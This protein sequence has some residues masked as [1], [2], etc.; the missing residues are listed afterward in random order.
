MFPLISKSLDWLKKPWQFTH[1]NLT[2]AYY[3]IT[4]Q[5]KDKWKTVFQTKYKHYKYSVMS[6]RLTNF[7]TSF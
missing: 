1:L 3:E 7:T 5:K 6:F 2:S 4:I